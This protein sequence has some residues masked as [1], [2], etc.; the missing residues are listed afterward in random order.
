[1]LAGKDT[2]PLY[3]LLCDNQQVGAV[4]AKHLGGIAFLKI[5]EE[6]Q[7]VRHSE[8][9]LELLEKEARQLGIKR[10]M[11]VTPTFDQR[12]IRA[13]ERCGFILANKDSNGDCWYNKDL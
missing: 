13:F 1:M 9:L 6:Y 12:M 3:V 8:I 4:D 7:G 5:F 2:T 11:T 10:I